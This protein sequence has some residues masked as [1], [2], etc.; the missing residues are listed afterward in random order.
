MRVLGM[1]VLGLA[2]LPLLADPSF[3]FPTTFKLEGKVITIVAGDFNNDGIGD[4]AVSYA[5]TTG[6][7][8]SSIALFL[9]SPDGHLVRKDLPP[10]NPNGNDVVRAVA[11]LNRDGNLDIITDY[12]VALGNG[13]GTFRPLTPFVTAPN[14]ALGTQGLAQPKTSDV[15]SVIEVADLNND[16]IPDLCWS[17]TIRL[18]HGDGTF[19]PPISTPPLFPNQNPAAPD[20]L[21]V[22]TVGDFDG[23]GFPDIVYS[24]IAGIT[25]ILFGNG[26]GTFTR[27]GVGPNVGNYPAALIAGDLNGDGKLDLVAASEPPVKLRPSWETEKG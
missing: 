3:L 11:D 18:G 21:A 19:G 16:G 7:L 10:I 14:V 2:S 8:T 4:F 6:Y 20:E 13:D 23:D 24:D 22:F 27:R 12:G 17:S 5:T 25:S 1:M 15:F 26:D 9:G